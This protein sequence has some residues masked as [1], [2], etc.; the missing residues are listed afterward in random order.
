MSKY[1]TE[2]KLQV[3][4]EYL[5]S[6]GQKRV[7]HLFEIGH[8]D[9]RKWSLAYQAHGLVGLNPGPQT[10]TAQFKMQVL[11]YMATHQ[12]SARSAA[13]HFN[14][15]SPS[16]IWMWQKL[17]NE[18]GITALQPKHTG[19]PLKF[20][21]SDI[22]ALLAKPLVELTHDELLRRAQYL[23]VENAYLKKL[24]ALAQQKD[25]ASKNKPK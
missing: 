12:L 20:K 3:V 4:N 17:Y 1:S 11:Q 22:K 15:A 6:G 25:L 8:S 2:F 21:P 24:E 9:V 13:A 23:E 16:T 18:D 19:R 14:I 10:H 5:K 7:A